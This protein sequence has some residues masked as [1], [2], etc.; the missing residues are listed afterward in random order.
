MYG[1]VSAYGQLLQEEEKPS[2]SYDI[3]KDGGKNGFY[4]LL[5]PEYT[6]TEDNL[7]MDND[8]RERLEEDS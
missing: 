8:E 1:L 6:D 2:L 3:K 5:D 4:E 7:S